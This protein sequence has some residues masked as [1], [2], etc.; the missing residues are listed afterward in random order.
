MIVAT[1]GAGFIGSNLVT[2]LQDRTAGEIAVCDRLGRDD[3][4]RN[5]A[6]CEL[7]AWVEPDD[8]LPFLAGHRDRIEAVV[9]LGAIS[10]TTETDADLIV[11]T[12]FGLTMRL[13]DWCAA[14][15]VPLIYASSAAT[16]GDG[17]AGFDDDG[18]VAALARLRPL[19]A[20]GWS[21]HLTDRRIARIVAEGGPR[22]PQWAGLKFFNVYG[23]NEGHKGAQ[24]SVVP[25]VWRQVRSGGS[26]QLFRSYRPDVPDGEQRRDF[27]WVG[28]A[29]AVMLWLLDH[30]EVSGLFNVGS[31]RA[32]SFN[33]LALAVFAAL[34]REPRIEY[35]EMPVQLRDRYQYFT[36]APIDRLRRAG[37]DAPMTTL[38]EGIH[39]YVRDHLGMSA[40]IG[41]VAGSSECR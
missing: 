39:R 28:D 2:A 12:N 3:K 6:G 32:R 1:G 8:L 41:N 15:R 29:V 4:W 33:D 13:W 37:Y 25:Q 18:S 26:A 27:V 10:S 38:E 22:P 9:H 30:P 11:Q 14:S 16:Y 24:Q 5:L 21:K 23:P 34:G 36:E 17:A 20:Y 40:A 35:V 7:A 19:N 31:G